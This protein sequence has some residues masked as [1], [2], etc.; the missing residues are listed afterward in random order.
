MILRIAAAGLMALALPAMAGDD[1]A[2]FTSFLG[3][4]LNIGTLD[5]VQARLGRT[6]LIENGDSED[7][8]ARVCYL[9]NKGV[10]SFFSSVPRLELSGLEVR[11]AVSGAAQGCRELRGTYAQQSTQLA[12]L[13]L[14]MSKA[15][16]AALLG[17]PLRWDGDSG[18]RLFE[19]EQ[20]MTPGERK[21]F[22]DSPELLLRGAFNVTVSVS[23]TFVE[24]RLVSFRVWKV[25]SA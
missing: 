6:R 25:V 11:E 24:D 7:Y 23:G 22:H 19:S 10:V 1:G 2:R 14:G 17:E 16:F 20:P 5:Q 18:Q 8:E 3:L 9:G 4:R 15:E 21:L 12:G 13:H